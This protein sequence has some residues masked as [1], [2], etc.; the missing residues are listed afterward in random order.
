MMK[1]GI[2]LLLAAAGLR[3]QSGEKWVT[4]WAASAHGP[5]PSG[6]AS[7]QPDQRFTFPVPA[8]GARDQT[9]RLMLLPA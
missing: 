8:A 9:F 7:A 3:A 5:Y 6:N 4:V 2:V 1:I